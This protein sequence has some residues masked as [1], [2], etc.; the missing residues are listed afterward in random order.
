MAQKNTQKNTL[1]RVEEVTIVGPSAR[2][3]CWMFMVWKRR[4]VLCL[5]AAWGNMPRVMELQAWCCAIRFLMCSNVAHVKRLCMSLHK[6]RT[7]DEIC[8][9]FRSSL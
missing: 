2:G 8:G 7:F 9:V 6:G 1:H 4:C 5:P 3:C